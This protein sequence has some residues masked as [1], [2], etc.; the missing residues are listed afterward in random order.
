MPLPIA[1]SPHA[2]VPSRSGYGNTTTVGGTSNDE[3]NAFLGRMPEDVRRQVGLGHQAQQQGSNLDQ[4]RDRVREA[5]NQAQQARLQQNAR[6][7]QQQGQ[8]PQNGYTS[9]RLSGASVLLQAQMAAG[10]TAS[11]ADP[12][13]LFSRG[14]HAYVQAGAQPGGEKAARAAQQAR[15]DRERGVEIDAPQLKS[16][17]FTA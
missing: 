3:V 5:Q 11:Q 2:V 9:L 16:V 10:E 4:S 14:H 6:N 8:N 7:S 17:N 1:V 13:R 15:L 12:S